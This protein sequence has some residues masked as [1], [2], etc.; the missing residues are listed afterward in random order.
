[1]QEIT[2]TLATDRNG[3]IIDPP[4]LPANAT[5]EVTFRVIDEHPAPTEPSKRR[6]SPRILGKG[7]ILGDIT[8][9]VVE[10]DAWESTQ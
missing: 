9:P 6:P 7:T 4:T 3:A 5:V 10:P 8:A 2:Q 1:M